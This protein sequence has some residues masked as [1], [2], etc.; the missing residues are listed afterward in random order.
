MAFYRLTG[1]QERGACVH[2]G[3]RHQEHDC[4]GAGDLSRQLRGRR[5]LGTPER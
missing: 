4:C 3:R 1:V 5:K 2:C